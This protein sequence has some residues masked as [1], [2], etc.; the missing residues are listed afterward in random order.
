M[1]IEA[2]I[3]FS[4]KEKIQIAKIQLSDPLPKEILVKIV[5]CGLCHTD[6][7]ESSHYPIILGHEG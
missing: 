6:F 7:Y 1:E 5:A 2:A 3:K 4:S